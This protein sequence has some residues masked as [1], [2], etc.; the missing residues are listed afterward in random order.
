MILVGGGELKLV[1]GVV[2]LR[3]CR[4]EKNSQVRTNRGSHLGGGEGKRKHVKFCIPRRSDQRKLPVETDALSGGWEN[5]HVQNEPSTLIFVCILQL[6]TNNQATRH[7]TARHDRTLT[8]TKLPFSGNLKS[9]WRQKAQRGRC[10]QDNAM[11]KSSERHFGASDSY[12][13]S[14]RLQQERPFRNIPETVVKDPLW[15]MEQQ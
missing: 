14:Q 7:D 10:Q 4:T 1:Y 9:F 5:D 13:L 8:T 3:L 15:Y 12:S 11:R 2:Q 6:Q